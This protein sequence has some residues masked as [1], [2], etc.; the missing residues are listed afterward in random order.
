MPTTYKVLG[1]IEPS[2]NSV[3]TVYTV[4]SA[5]QAVVSTI[6]ACNQG[7]GSANI[8][9]AVQPDGET[10][11][12]KHY[13]AYDVTVGAGQTVAFTIGITA[14]ASD[15]ISVRSSTATV[16]FNVFGTEIS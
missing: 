3:T 2:A 4:P 15:I 1:Q 12:D 7:T 10:L 6:T 11:A 5:T 13:V 14:D 8:R 9:I 16:S